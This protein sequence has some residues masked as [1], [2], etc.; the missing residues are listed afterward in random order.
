MLSMKTGRLLEEFVSDY[1]VFDLETTGISPYKDKIV[2]ISAVK[3]VDRKVKAEFSRLVN[4]EC[5]I[6]EGASAVN[7]IYDEMVENE[8]TIEEI[9]PNFIDFIEDYILVGHNIYAFDL[10]FIYRDSEAI[11]GKFPDNC[12]VDT[13]SLSR[14]CMPELAHHR[15]T[16]LATYFGISTEGA[17]R[18]LKDCQMT[19][20]VY[21]FLRVE[22]KKFE[23]GKKKIP[24]CRRCGK[25]MILRN[26]RFGKFW[27]CKGYPECI[28]TENYDE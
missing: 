21:E 7:G 28:Y 19:Q 10:N 26:G 27:G 6:S 1:V 17:H 16:D 5:H 20:Q 24:I 3:V 8:P 13:L 11:I 15:M 4:P 14:K 2:E 18:A 22:M 25:T 9:L 12:Y 23:E